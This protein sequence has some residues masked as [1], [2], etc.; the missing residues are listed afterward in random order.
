MIANTA[1]TCDL[2]TTNEVGGKPEFPCH[3]CGE[4]CYSWGYLGSHGLTFI[5]DAAS[6]LSKTFRIGWR[7][8][9]RRCDVCGNIQ[10]FAPVAKDTKSG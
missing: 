10:A 5:P 2:L 4:R 7:L 8:R 9:A 1:A 6:F 3:V